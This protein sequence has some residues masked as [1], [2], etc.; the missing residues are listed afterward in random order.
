METPKVLQDYFKEYLLNNLEGLQKEGLPKLDSFINHLEADVKFINFPFDDKHKDLMN[1]ELLPVIQKWSG[2][3][4]ELE[5][6]SI[7]GMRLYYSGSYLINHMDRPRTHIL[8]VTFS[9]A[10]LN[11]RTFEILEDEEVDEGFP[12]IKGENIAEEDEWPIEIYSHDGDI[13]RYPHHPGTMVIYESAK[14][15]HGRPYKNPKYIHVGLFVHYKPKEFDVVNNNI[16]DLD[17]VINKKNRNYQYI[18]T[19][20]VEPINPVYSDNTFGS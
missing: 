10:K 6:T 11:P 1:K 9:V 16:D 20:S 7:Y 19:E 17:A 4:E 2:V 15:I 14:C 18:S 12:F 8:S 13:Y 3:N 5:I